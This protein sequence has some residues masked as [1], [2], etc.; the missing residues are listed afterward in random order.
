MMQGSGGV[1]AGLSRHA[2]LVTWTCAIVNSYFHVRP[3]SPYMRD[4]LGMLI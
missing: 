1:Y 2:Y 3:Q 4:F